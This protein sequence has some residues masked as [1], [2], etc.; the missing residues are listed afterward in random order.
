MENKKIQIELTPLQLKSFNVDIEGTSPLLM[1]K[2]SDASKK[3]MMDKQLKKSSTKK[4][5]DIKQEVEE[6]IYREGDKIVFPAI[7]F[8]K[9]CVEV[10][11]YL[12][13]LD[14]KLVKGAMQI[15]GQYVELKFKKQT[16]NEAHV[17][18]AS[19]V[20]MIRYRPEFHD[21]KVNI[22]FIYNASQI[23]PQQII[24]LLKYAGFH[25]GVGDWTPQHSGSFGMFE[26]K[27][28]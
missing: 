10:A 27:T 9:A 26:V 20:S 2:F 5:R 1:H 4:I 28:K 21:W 18:L 3:E 23:T 24:E 25:I 8:K 16:V 14:K 19:G 13:N 17:K 7:A 15:I 22:R 12:E 11:P 6:C